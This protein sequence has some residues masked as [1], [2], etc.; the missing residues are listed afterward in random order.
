MP[1]Y[2]Y[3]CEKCGNIREVIQ[4]FSDPPLATCEACGGTLERLISP[5]AI[6]FKGAGWYVNDYG[7]NNVQKFQDQKS[8]EKIEKK[9][10]LS[11]SDSKK[12][13]KPEKSASVK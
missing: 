3:C 7:K 9:A 12:E 5:S 11:S 10:E 8:S 6:Q 13:S 2:E 1:L 4:K